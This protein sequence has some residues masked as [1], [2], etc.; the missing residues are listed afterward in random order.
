MN[1][2]K[3]KIYCYFDY[4]DWVHNYINVYKDWDL[5]QTDVERYEHK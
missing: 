1:K 4:W 3:I 5:T 2:L